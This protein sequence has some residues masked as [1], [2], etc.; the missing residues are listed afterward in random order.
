MSVENTQQPY[1]VGS[2][3]Q[4]K[5]RALKLRL[6]DVAEQIRV[7]PEVLRKL[8]ANDFD[9]A[10]EPVYTRGFLRTYANFLGLNGAEIVRELVRQKKLPS[11]ADM[12]LPIPVEERA[13]PSKFILW[14]GLA[15][16]F[17]IGF[18]WHG[19]SFFTTLKRVDVIAAQQ[20]KHLPNTVQTP[21]VLPKLALSTMQEK[22]EGVFQ[23]PATLETDDSKK[24]KKNTAVKPALAS[25]PE[26]ERIRLYALD[27]VWF[28]VYKE[29]QKQPYWAGTLKKGESFWAPQGDG[30]LVD[31]GLPPA[32]EVFIDGASFGISGVIDRHVRKLP[33]EVNYLQSTYFGQKVYLQ[34]NLK[35]N[36]KKN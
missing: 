28:K 26:G 14:G 34:P 30:I 7:R 6:V 11:G 24:N 8:E 16:V 9:L 4:K 1:N 15:I 21:E 22:P 36:S 23:T 20:E 3:L 31:I 2:V 18:A 5:R 32:L 27:D 17:I 29:T 35:P 13:L 10:S 12:H 33:L 25:G 19:V